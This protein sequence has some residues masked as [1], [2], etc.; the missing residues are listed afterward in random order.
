[1]HAISWFEIPVGNMN[2]A[3]KFYETILDIR[4]TRQNVMGWEMALFPRNGQDIAGSLMHG[5][6]YEP[7]PFGPLVYLNGSDDL[8]VALSRVEPSGG[9]ITV[10]KT[11]IAPEIGHYACFIDSEG[12]RLALFSRN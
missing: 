10:P 3:Q 11:Q 1:M 7:T 2:R 9:K 8:Q 12:N 6:T 4:L 5:P